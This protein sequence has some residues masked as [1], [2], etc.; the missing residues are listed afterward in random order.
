MVKEKSRLRGYGSLR[1][2]RSFPNLA[3]GMAGNKRESYDKEQ[4]E[5]DS[6][7]WKDGDQKALPSTRRQS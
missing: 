6:P 3:L 4:L 2:R 5:Y 1:F 7:T